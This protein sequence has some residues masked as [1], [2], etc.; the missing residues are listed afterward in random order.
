MSRLTSVKG[1]IKELGEILNRWDPLEVISNQSAS[2]VSL[3]EYESYVPLLLRLLEKNPT[4]AEVAFFLGRISSEEMGLNPS[5]E[6]DNA[7]AK[8]ICDWY[9]TAVG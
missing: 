9:R 6:R 1:L 5:P 4:Q 3:T 7:A 8:L 2:G